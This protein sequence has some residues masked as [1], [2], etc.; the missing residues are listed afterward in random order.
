L[1]DCDEENWE[2]GNAAD[3][4]SELEDTQQMKEPI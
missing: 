1:I 4:I 2:T 3:E